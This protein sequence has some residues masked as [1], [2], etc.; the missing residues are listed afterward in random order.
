MLEHLSDN[1]YEAIDAT[2]EIGADGCWYDRFLYDV[3]RQAEG[4]NIGTDLVRVLDTNRDFEAGKGPVTYIE[5][6]DHSTVVNRVGGRRR[7]W[8]AQVP[9]IALLTTPG[10]VLIHNG[11]E[12]GDD[13]YLPTMAATGCSRAR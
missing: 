4:G 9:L 6:H 13:H 5:N 2:N 11:Q 12:F 7:W 3:P 8:K 1:R 10:A